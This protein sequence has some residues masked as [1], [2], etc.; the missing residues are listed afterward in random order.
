MYEC[1]DMWFVNKNIC[2]KKK[3]VRVHDV[4]PAKNTLFLFSQGAAAIL[5]GSHI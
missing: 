1:F 3:D 4:R 5:S 2:K